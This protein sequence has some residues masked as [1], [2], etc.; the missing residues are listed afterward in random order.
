LF[1][2]QIKITDATKKVVASG[3]LKRTVNFGFIACLNFD[4]KKKII[5][6]IRIQTE[7]LEEENMKII[8]TK[9]MLEASC[10][11][12]RKIIV[13]TEG[14]R[15]CDFTLLFLNLLMFQHTLY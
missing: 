15:G 3:L 12:Y 1:F 2:I 7:K 8:D 14:C 10:S 13:N 11:S 9:E 6:K 5:H 4:E